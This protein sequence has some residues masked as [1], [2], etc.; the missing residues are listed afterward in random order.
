MQMLAGEQARYAGGGQDDVGVADAVQVVSGVEQ[1]RVVA[2]VSEERNDAR[3]DES[4]ASHHG[5][6]LGAVE[7]GLGDA[8]DAVGGRARQPGRED[9]EGVEVLAG[10]DLVEQG[11]ERC[12]AGV[13]TMTPATCSSRFASV[14]S[15]AMLSR[16]MLSGTVCSTGRAP[17]CSNSRSFCSA[18]IRE[19]SI[20]AFHSRSFSVPGVKRTITT[21]VCRSWSSS[22]KARW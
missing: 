9:A 11:P 3:A 19:A 2:C 10:V 18:E 1:D 12:G 21:W 6:L 7:V 8:D 14:I 16:P 20:R 17:R 13:W 4:A 5:D 22:A 15:V